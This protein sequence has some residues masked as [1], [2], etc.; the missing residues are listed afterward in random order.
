MR[1]T[2]IVVEDARAKS[3]LVMTFSLKIAYNKNR[4][5][6]ARSINVKKTRTLGETSFTEKVWS[7]LIRIWRSKKIN[8]WISQFI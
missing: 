3:I 7:G 8:N 6:T 5:S 1:K 2:M 4:I